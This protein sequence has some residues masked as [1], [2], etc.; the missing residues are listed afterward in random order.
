[1]LILLPGMPFPSIVHERTPKPIHIN[2][3]PNLP[4]YMWLTNFHPLP[5]HGLYYNT[6]RGN[7]IMYISFLCRH[8]KPLNAIAIFYLFLFL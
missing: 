4:R 7:I 5:Y 3:F 2:S 6:Y 1:M 8:T